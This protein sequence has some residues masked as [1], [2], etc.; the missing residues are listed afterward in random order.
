MSR[1][2]CRFSVEWPGGGV[3]CPSLA[4]K[5]RRAVSL[6]MTV[7]NSRSPASVRAGLAAIVT[8]RRTMQPRIR[9]LVGVALV[10]LILAVMPSS[11]LANCSLPD[12]IEGEVVYNADYKVVQ[13]CNGSHW[14]L[15][16]GST[17]DARIGA[18]N[19]GKW[20]AANGAGDKIDCTA[21]AP[22]TVVGS[23]KQV[24]FNDGGTALAGAAQLFWDKANNM[25]GIG[26]TEPTSK[27]DVRGGLR[28]ANTDFVPSSAGTFADLGLSAASGNT[29]VQLQGYTNGGVN[30]AD[31]LFNPVSGSVAVGASAPHASALLDVNSTAKGLLPPRMTTAQR[32]AIASPATGL[33]VYN[34]TNAQFEFFNGT[35]WTG[36]GSMTTGQIAAFASATCPTGWTEYTPARGRFLRGIDNGAG[37]DPS[38]TRAPGNAQADELASHTHTIT[39]NGVALKV[40]DQTGN[41]GGSYGTVAR[42]DAGGSVSARRDMVIGNAGGAETRPKNVAVI[43]CQYSG[44]GNVAPASATVSGTANYVAKFTGATVVGDSQIFDNGTNVGIGTTSPAAPLDIYSGMNFGLPQTTGTGK[45]GAN[46]KFAW[47]GGD[48]S[49]NNG[50]MGNGTSW[51]QVQRISDN[52]DTFPFVINPNGG[53]VGIGTASPDTKLEVSGVPLSGNAPGLQISNSG[54][55]QLLNMGL[56]Y[57]GVANGWIDANGPLLLQPGGGNV[58]IGTATP[59]APMHVIERTIIG[60]AGTSGTQQVAVNLVTLGG[61]GGNDLSAAGTRGW[62]LYGRGNAYSVSAEQ[63]DLGLAYWNGST[64]RIPLNIDSATGNVGIG[65]ASP[66]A[67]LDIASATQTAN[68]GGAIRY[69]ATAGSYAGIALDAPSPGASKSLYMHYGDHIGGDMDNQLR[70]G[71]YADDFGVWE[72]NPYVFDM[73]APNATIYVAHNGYVGVGTANPQYMLDVGGTARVLTLRGGAGSNFHIDANDS[74]RSIYLNWYSTGDVYARSTLLASSDERLKQNIDVLPNALERIAQIRG[75]SFEWKDSARP[76]RQ[77]GVIAQDVEK[78]FPEMVN[79]DQD[80]F[81]TVAYSNMIAP[82]IEAVKELKAAN[83]NQAEAM[84]K[85]R[86]EFD[87]YKAAH[88]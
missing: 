46:T 55:G 24:I 58:G 2:S 16:G 7:L 37:N 57:G 9:I 22:T 32:D 71:R 56:W 3:V 29:N 82:L 59:A 28:I 6:A 11:A 73:D 64:W 83:D 66:D 35:A 34:T 41:A 18:L 25:F 5:E 39:D 72:A 49:V 79:E 38:G 52:S 17:L 84:E 86:A 47:S 44:G 60:T 31:I 70:F 78:V 54:T 81:K 48:V 8:N 19:A 40:Y 85:L 68:L 65:T 15:M 77:I 61:S 27:L 36:I 62:S 33:M 53:N 51:L 21:D 50:L 1:K 10:S 67:A 45:G 13:Y 69:K 30:P 4:A 74:T 20:C 63:N 87:A 12:G 76:G 26:T 43:F 23:D 80:G 88:P 75:V 42:P 14:A